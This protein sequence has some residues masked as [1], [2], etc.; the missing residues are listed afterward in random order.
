MN[1]IGKTSGLKVLEIGSGLS[2]MCG[3]VKEVDKQSHTIAQD[4]T[5]ECKDICTW[6][7]DYIIG[8]CEENYGE[9]KNK[10]P[11]D[12]I[13]LTHVIEH[14]S[15]PVDFLI[16]I[17]PLLS[18]TGIIFIT[19]PYQPP[20]WDKANN[21][22]EVWKKWS[23]NHVPAHLQYFIPESVKA[24]SMITNLKILSYENHHDGGSAFELMLTK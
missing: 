21:N 4:V 16:Q 15:Y 11:Y 19:A 20:N 9:L 3:A 12:L 2:W 22:I 6:V 13:S 5:P 1:K 23:Y 10:G 17:S 8:S 18:D 24:I 14:L 7:D